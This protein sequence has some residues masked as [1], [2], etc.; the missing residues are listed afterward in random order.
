M[1]AR[2]RFKPT[3]EQRTKVKL[4]AQTGLAPEDIAVLNELRSVK[5]LQ[6]HF[7]KE[8][9]LGAAEGKAIVIQT[10]HRMAIS[11]KYPMMTRFWN[12]TMGSA[13]IPNESEDPGFDIKWIKVV[14]DEDPE[15][16]CVQR[17]EGDWEYYVFEPKGCPAEKREKR[18]IALLKAKAARLQVVE[19][20]AA[21]ALAEA[22]AA[23][24]EEEKAPESPAE[25]LSPAEP[26]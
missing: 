21:A 17:P 12:D 6:R 23:S 2:K 20:K 8:L 7:R 25:S 1:T 22:P 9:E 26:G 13:T 11:G 10:C 5:S 24:L 19:A 3:P 15:R 16:G 18:R 4:M 14:K